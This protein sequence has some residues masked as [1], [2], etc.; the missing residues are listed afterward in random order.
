ME[1]YKIIGITHKDGTPRTDGRY[2]ERIGRICE[3]P[4]AHLGLPMIINYISKAD[5]SDYRG[6]YLTTSRVIDI[7]ESKYRI[8]IETMNSFYEFKKVREI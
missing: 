2:P 8:Q 6:Y 1:K 5:G 7:G 3:K 4:I